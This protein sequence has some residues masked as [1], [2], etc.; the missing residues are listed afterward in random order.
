MLDPSWLLGVPPFVL[1]W[2]LVK[3]HI[4]VNAADIDGWEAAKLYFKCVIDELVPHG[5]PDPDR[6][7]DEK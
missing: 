2:I 7:D 3:C 1:A 4:E 5:L 6:F